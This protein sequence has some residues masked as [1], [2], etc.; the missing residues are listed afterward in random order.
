[1]LKKVIDGLLERR[2]AADELFM[3]EALM[4]WTVGTPRASRVQPSLRG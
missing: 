4:A 2:S 1:M 3:F